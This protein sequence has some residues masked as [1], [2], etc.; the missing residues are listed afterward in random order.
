MK[1]RDLNAENFI[2][3]D[4]GLQLQKGQRSF[5]ERVWNLNLK[6]FVIGN[7]YWF[8]NFCKRNLKTKLSTEDSFKLGEANM[9]FSEK[10][11]KEVLYSNSFRSSFSL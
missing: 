4:L 8:S 2:D 6:Y 9:L 11:F 10:M 3:D 7:D 5:K 1:R